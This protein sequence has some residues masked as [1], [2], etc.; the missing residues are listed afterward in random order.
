M[1]RHFALLIAVLA[2]PGLAPAA[3]NLLEGG[4]FERG[5]AGWSEL[6]T[7]TPGG[8]TVLDS[9][10]R[11][12]GRNSLRIEHTGPR[13]WSLQQEKPLPVKPGQIY[14]LSG[15]VRVQG[16]GNTTLCVTLRDAQDQ[17]TDWAFGAA[18]SRETPGWRE[19]RSRFMIPPGTKTM[20]PRLI[21]DGPATIWLDDAVLTL[22]GSLDTLRAKNLPESVQVSSPTARSRCSTAAPSGRGRSGP[23]AT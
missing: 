12:G 11:H 20:L 6:W 1:I 14:Q 2:L 8:N 21:G 9:G 5:M 13:D 18:S 16:E 19:L 10:L 4:D 15:W 22:A 7:R 17:V 3:E 23:V